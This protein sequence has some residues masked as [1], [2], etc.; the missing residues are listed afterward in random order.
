[1]EDFKVKNFEKENVGKLFP[2]Y[3][4]MD[5]ENAK[6]FVKNISENIFKINLSDGRALAQRIHNQSVSVG[7]LNANFD[8]FIFSDIF[9]RLSIVPKSTVFINWFHFDTVDAFDVKA[10]IE[11]FTD[12][13]YPQSDDIDIFDDTFSWVISVEHD[14]TVRAI[15]KNAQTN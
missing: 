1:M 11:Y 6:H 8:N 9:S 7:G 14:G 5:G 3:V 4:S 12:I 15:V 2:R 13:W 10:L